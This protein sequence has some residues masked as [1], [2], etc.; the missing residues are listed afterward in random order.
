MLLNYLKKLYL[1]LKILS[2]KKTLEQ[3]NEKFQ[4]IKRKTIIIY[5]S[6]IKI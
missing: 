2:N 1:Q 4:K 6:I 3:I 5:R